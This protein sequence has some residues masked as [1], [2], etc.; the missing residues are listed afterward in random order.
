MT[1]LIVAIALLVVFALRFRR[2]NQFMPAGLMGTV[3]LFCAA[4][5]AI[6]LAL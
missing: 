1:F 6:A 4:V 3:S 5:F 2:T